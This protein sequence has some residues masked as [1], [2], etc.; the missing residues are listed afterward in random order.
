[1]SDLDEFLA[2]H[3]PG[4]THPV[5]EFE[6]SPGDA[7]DTSPF[8]IIRQGNRVALVNPLPFTEY[9]DIDVRGFTD[10]ENT[11]SQVLGMTSG[12]RHAM[13]QKVN[14]AMILIGEKDD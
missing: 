7:R 2:R 13:D 14:L 10:G 3:N 4:N 12:K 6:V 8:I 9:L 5:M 1:M 11:P